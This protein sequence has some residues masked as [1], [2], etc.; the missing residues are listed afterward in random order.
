[1]DTISTE[2]RSRNM[3]KIRSKDTFPE[4]I[5]RSYLFSQGFRFRLHRNDLPGKPD[6]V[7]PKY[8]TVIFVNGCFWHQHFGCSRARIPKTNPDYWIPKLEKNK[9]RFYAQLRE[10]K[11]LGWFII[12]VWEC[13]LKKSNRQATLEKLP[14]E[15]I[16]HLGP[17][18]KKV[19]AK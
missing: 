11:S 9:T 10:L 13:S 14:E 3:S 2:K 6:I 1:M 7:L 19:F 8:R 4:K 5:V 18:P 16:S 12:V 17:S 15:I